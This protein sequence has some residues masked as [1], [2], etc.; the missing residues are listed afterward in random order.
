MSVEGENVYDPRRH[1]YVASD[2]PV[3]VWA[4]YADLNGWP[5]D[6][7]SV[8]RRADWMDEIVGQDGRPR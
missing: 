8:A 3:L 4:W 2:N 7:A 5:V 1:R 6:W